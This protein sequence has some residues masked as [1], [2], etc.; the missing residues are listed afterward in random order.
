MQ[1]NKSFEKQAV[2]VPE[3][4]ARASEDEDVLYNGDEMEWSTGR[5]EDTPFAEGRLFPLV[6]LCPPQSCTCYRA[7]LKLQSVG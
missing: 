3:V 6:L 1:S 4:T 2:H 5:S 7:A